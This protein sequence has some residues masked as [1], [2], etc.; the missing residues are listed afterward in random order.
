MILTAL[1]SQADVVELE[2]AVRCAKIYISLDKGTV[3][4]NDTIDSNYNP[5]EQAEFFAPGNLSIYTVQRGDTTL[6]LRNGMKTDYRLKGKQLD[7]YFWP[8]EVLGNDLLSNDPATMLDDAEVILHLTAG[9]DR[10]KGKVEVAK[11]VNL[12]EKYRE[13][14]ENQSLSGDITQRALARVPEW[15]AFFGHAT[16]LM[17]VNYELFMSQQGTTLEQQELTAV[18]N[19]YNTNAAPHIEALKDLPDNNRLQRALSIAEIE[20][21]DAQTTVLTGEIGSDNQI[22]TVTAKRYMETK[23]DWDSLSE[24]DKN[25][26]LE[27]EDESEANRILDSIRVDSF[28]V[29]RGAVLEIR[30]PK[31]GKTVELFDK[32][33]AHESDCKDIGLQWRIV[34]GQLERLETIKNDTTDVQQT[35]RYIF[36]AKKE[37]LFRSYEKIYVWQKGNAKLLSEGEYYQMEALDGD[38]KLIRKEPEDNYNG[39]E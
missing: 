38:D 2:G 9:K 37:N 19:K 12:K 29:C 30:S 24:E 27:A 21:F 25:R 23:P 14:I 26:I 11:G 13:V 20:T 35:T 33:A 8:D 17:K 28:T 31:L 4:V 34:D 3:N 39:Q 7:I 15:K 1:A 5:E 10:L 36:D 22:Y 32:E 6:L 18:F 16:D